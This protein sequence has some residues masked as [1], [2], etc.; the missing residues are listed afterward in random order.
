MS[1]FRDFCVGFLWLVLLMK[2]CLQKHF[3]K[4][5]FYYNILY[6]W[7]SFILGCKNMTLI[8]L[9]TSPKHSGCG[10]LREWTL[11]MGNTRLECFLRGLKFSDEKIRGLKFLRENLRGIKSIS[12][13]DHIFFKISIF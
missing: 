1:F 4:T 12:K 11:L 3:C 5:L 9:S 7:G 10:T 6:L 13:L 8:Y 2:C